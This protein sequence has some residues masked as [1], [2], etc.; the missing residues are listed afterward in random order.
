MITTS[1]T[2]R[3]REATSIYGRRSICTQLSCCYDPNDG[4]NVGL[5]TQRRS[6]PE[7][8]RGIAVF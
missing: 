4:E 8:N 7:L 6:N 5:I 2:T 3:D 1:L